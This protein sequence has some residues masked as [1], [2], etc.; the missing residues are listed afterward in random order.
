MLKEEGV[1]STFER[2]LHKTTSS[3]YV[4]LL[5]NLWNTHPPISHHHPN[6]PTIALPIFP[7]QQFWDLTAL[8]NCAGKETQ[9]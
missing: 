4:H 5:D 9:H 3:A 7:Q 8:T 2:E 6:I 1:S